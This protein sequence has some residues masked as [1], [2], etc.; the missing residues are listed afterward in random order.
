V[1]PL[2]GLRLRWLGQLIEHVLRR[3]LS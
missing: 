2:R 1:Q 3:V